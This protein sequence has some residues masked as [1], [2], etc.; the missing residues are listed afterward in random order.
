M[1]LAIPSWAFSLFEGWWSDPAELPVRKFI[2]IRVTLALLVAY[3]C[4]LTL[5][6]RVSAQD[7]P[8]DM[9]LG[10][11]ARSFRRKPA[12]PEVVIDNDNFSK[13]VDDAE[14]RRAAGSTMVFSFDPGGKSFQVSS[15]DVSCSLSFTAKSSSLLSDPLM[16]DEL[17]RSELAKLDGP[18]MIDGDSLQVSMHNGTAWELREIVIGLTIVRR[19]EPG[20]TASYYGQARIFPAVAGSNSRPV[21]DSVQ[22]QPDVTMLLRV[23]GSA[24]PSA[25]AL[26]R[27]QLNFAL[28]PDQE[29]HWAI[30][31]AKGVPPQTPPE[32]MPLQSD[33]APVQ[34]PTVPAEAGPQV[35]PLIPVQPS[36]PPN[37]NAATH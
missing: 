26:F 37:P 10:D 17:P 16:L 2:S 25:T 1:Q 12:S 24:A 4:A 14:S 36:T 6:Q 18:A 20:D 8:N 33:L 30:V 15:P 23:K 5:P 11:V 35:S 29:W 3:M 13:V 22:K 21:Q 32:A 27:T 9:P 19:P 34:L 28:F 7:D 31:R